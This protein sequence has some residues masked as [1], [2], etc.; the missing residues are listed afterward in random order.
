MWSGSQSGLGDS[1]QE[2]L[3]E[4]HERAVYTMTAAPPLG[5]AVISRQAEPWSPTNTT[6]VDCR[7]HWNTSGAARRRTNIRTRCTKEMCTLLV[8]LTRV[9]LAGVT[10]QSLVFLS[11]PW[12]DLTLFYVSVGESPHGP[13]QQHFCS[14]PVSVW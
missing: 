13:Y 2:K 3:R 10:H 8:S 9:H 4:E 14:S 11:S 12:Y 1:D 7:E 5:P 6:N